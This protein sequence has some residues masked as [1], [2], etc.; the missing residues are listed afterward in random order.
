MMCSLIQT[1]NAVEIR[2]KEFL[3]GL[4]KNLANTQGSFYSI[5]LKLSFTLI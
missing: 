1:L 2:Y 3:D 5:M 4:I